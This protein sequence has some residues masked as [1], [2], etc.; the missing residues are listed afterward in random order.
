L[1]RGGGVGLTAATIE[2]GE[3]FDQFAAND[4]PIQDVRTL[5]DVRLV[6]CNGA[7]AWSNKPW[8]TAI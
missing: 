3:H 2:P 5:R 4:D 6:S 1:P 8:T 7:C